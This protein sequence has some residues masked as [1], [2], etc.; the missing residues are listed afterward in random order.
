[1]NKKA[2]IAKYIAALPVIL[3]LANS[4]TAQT[5]GTDS[6]N[7]PF[8]PSP[9]A[10]GLAAI[11]RVRTS[12]AVIPAAIG[13]AKPI[14][15]GSLASTGAA[16]LVSTD[17]TAVYRIGV[18]DIVRIDLQNV[19]G[20]PKFLRVQADGTID[21]PLAGE[22]VAIAG[23]TPAEAE[24]MIVQ[25]IKLVNNARVT[26]RVREYASHIVSVWG[27][28]DQPGEQQIQRDA[29]P[30]Y[31][32]RAGTTIDS[33]ADRVRINR[34]SST[35]TEEYQL[36]DVRLGTVLIYP[37]DSIEFANGEKMQ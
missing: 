5:I 23:K 12:D 22:N 35:M 14:P 21:F 8:A 27:L 30:F 20:A 31:V 26:V 9:D 4:L 29:V 19:P 2:R 34:G 25:S 3:C 10:T 7:N 17:P 1:M 6:R 13:S 28:V 24:K 16:S 36:S 33:R 11:A 37:G 18:K 32:I 15:S